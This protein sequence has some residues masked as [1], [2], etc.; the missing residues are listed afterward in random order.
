[1]P[2]ISFKKQFREDILAGRKRQT[3]RLTRRAAVG[4]LASLYTGMRTKYCAKICV[5]TI[6][7]V[8]PV[9]IDDAGVMLDG[10]HVDRER[11]AR[12]DGFKSFDEMRDF[13]RK[14]YGEGNAMRGWVHFWDPPAIRDEGVGQISSIA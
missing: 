10:S 9:V 4:D 13:Q 8:L 7:R 5:V 11:F 12:A 14:H 3:V 1:M 2:A 6:T